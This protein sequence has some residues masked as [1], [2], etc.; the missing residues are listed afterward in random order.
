[1]FKLSGKIG[2]TVNVSWSEPKDASNS[3]DVEAAERALQMTTGWFCNPI[4]G[5]GDYPDVMKT[6]LAEAAK[7]LQ[8]E[9][10]LLPEF[11]EED[12]RYNRGKLAVS[13]MSL[14]KCHLG[15]RD[16]QRFLS[17]SFS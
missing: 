17:R 8:L 14:Q 3:D 1:M 10:S 9:H 5:N 15:P 7:I 4:F 6:R 11:S 12:K 2:I 13:L 16:S